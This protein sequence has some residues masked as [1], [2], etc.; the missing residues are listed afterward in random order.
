MSFDSSNIEDFASLLGAASGIAGQFSA[1]DQKIAAGNMSAAGF[2][3]DAASI[4][5]I[6]DYNIAVN[7]INLSRRLEEIKLGV[8]RTASTQRTQ[9]A[10]TGFS[11]SSQSFLDIMNNTLNDAS[12]RLVMERND[13]EIINVQDRYVAEVQMVS[14]ESAARVEQFN[15]QTA[16]FNRRMAGIQSGLKGITGLAGA[17]GGLL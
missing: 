4:A 17:V 7:K 9:A 11:S 16:A 5:A 8:R 13:Q 12:D 3:T 6:T 10:S 2:R 14:L 15:A 1:A